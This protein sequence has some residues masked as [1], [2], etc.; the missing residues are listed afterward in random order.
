M[1]YEEY[2]TAYNEDPFSQN[3]V[4]LGEALTTSMVADRNERWKELISGTNLPRNSNS[5]KAWA[6]ISKLNAEK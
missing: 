3:T 1:L 6:T 5:E 4:E 2:T